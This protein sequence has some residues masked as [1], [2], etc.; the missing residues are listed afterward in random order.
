[1]VESRS[2]N[3]PLPVVV[4]TADVAV[5]VVVVVVVVVHAAAAE[6]VAPPHLGPPDLAAYLLAVSSHLLRGR[7]HVGFGDTILRLISTRMGTEYVLHT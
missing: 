2:A 4:A 5:A 6:A 7:G 1:M 3:E